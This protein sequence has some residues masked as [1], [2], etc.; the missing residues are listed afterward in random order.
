MPSDTSP[1]QGI[2]SQPSCA[3]FVLGAGLASADCS[4]ARLFEGAIGYPFSDEFAGKP[5]GEAH[6]LESPYVDTYPHSTAPSAYRNPAE[7]SVVAAYP[8]SAGMEAILVLALNTHP[9]SQPCSPAFALNAWF[10]GREA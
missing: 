8:V 1:I 10:T 6:F 5:K 7:T 2:R 3:G 4:A 9:S